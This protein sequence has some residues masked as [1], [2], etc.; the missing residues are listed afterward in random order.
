MWTEYALL[1]YFDLG[2]VGRSL[3]GFTQAS[4]LEEQTVT[5]D[6]QPLPS[7]ED[8]LCRGKVVVL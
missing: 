3:E 7:M 4:Q 8:Q 2:C 1:L 5:T 6:H